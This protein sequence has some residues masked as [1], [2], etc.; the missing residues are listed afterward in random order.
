M[1]RIVS[2]EEELLKARASDFYLN[3]W[4]PTV[5]ST[6]LQWMW[7]C[8]EECI[9][10]AIASET[11]LSHIFVLTWLPSELVQECVKEEQKIRAAKDKTICWTRA[12]GLKCS[13]KCTSWFCAHISC[14]KSVEPKNY[15]PASGFLCMTWWFHQLPCTSFILPLPLCSCAF[16][17]LGERVHE[18]WGNFNQLWVGPQPT[19]CEQRL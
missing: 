19:N 16:T 10:V 13:W 11:F 15:S 2:S 9:M 7:H 4:H 5:H 3:A 12:N 17:F 18:L 14:I 8:F 6:H 1:N